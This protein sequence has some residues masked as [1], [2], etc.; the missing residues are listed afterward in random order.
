MNSK[1]KKFRWIREEIELGFDPPLV[2]KNEIAE[3][4]KC[5][6][7]G[8]LAVYLA[9]ADGLEIIGKR[10]YAQGLITEQQWMNVCNKYPG[11][12]GIED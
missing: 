2:M 4:E 10:Y 11:E 6:L 3:A 1:N 5:D 8:N 12:W 7:E 9:I